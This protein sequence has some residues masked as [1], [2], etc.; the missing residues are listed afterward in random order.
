MYLTTVDKLFH[1][2]CMHAHILTYFAFFHPL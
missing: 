2:M 1:Q